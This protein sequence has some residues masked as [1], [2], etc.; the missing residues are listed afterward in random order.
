MQPRHGITISQRNDDQI[1]HRRP[2]IGGRHAG[3]VR[4]LSWGTNLAA[5]VIASVLS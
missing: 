4:S 5:R 2:L 3:A 1:R